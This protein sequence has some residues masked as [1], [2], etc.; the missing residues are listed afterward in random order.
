MKQRRI[1]YFDILNILACFGV[2]CL[3]QN[4][5][6][7]EYDIHTSVFKEALI[8]EV[9]FFWAVPVFFM[10][11]GATLFDYRTR[12]STKDFLIRRAKRI[13]IPFLFFSFLNLI[14]RCK[15]GTFTIEDYSFSNLLTIILFNQHEVVYWFFLPMF[16]T[17]LCMPV[18][19]LLKDQ[20]RILWYMFFVGFLTLSCFPLLFRAIGSAWNTSANFPMTGGY[21]IFTILG[22]QLATTDFSKKQRASFYALAICSA[23]FRYFGTICLSNKAGS[24]DRTFF[25]YMQ[26]HSVF[27]ACGVFIFFKQLHLERFF[28]TPARI[29]RLAAISSCSFGIYLIHIVV[30]FYEPRFTN[31]TT[32]SLLYRTAGCFLT[33]GISFAIIFTAK[34]I[35]IIKKLIP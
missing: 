13:L 26:F 3:H 28:S 1:L 21:L 7:H 18:L 31:W 4:G 24:L 2:I 20:K 16:A 17:Y 14:W 27:L 29:K 33:Y 23:L 32:D 6:V 5:I 34:K 12:Y 19:S 11:S 15:N 8:F 25:D 30:Q 9:G 10:L 22:Y 35:P